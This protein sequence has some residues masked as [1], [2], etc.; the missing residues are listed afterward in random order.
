[1]GSSCWMNDDRATEFTEINKLAITK[2]GDNPKRRFQ[3]T[4]VAVVQQLPTPAIDYMHRQQM[5]ALAAVD[6][7]NFEGAYIMNISFGS[8]ARIGNRKNGEIMRVYA[9]HH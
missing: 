9:T 1:M 3:K 5:I 6:V 8:S 7:L 4:E 2:K